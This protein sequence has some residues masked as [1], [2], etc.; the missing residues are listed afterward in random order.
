MNLMTDDNNEITRLL[1]H[2]EHPKET[3]YVRESDQ[4]SSKATDDFRK[5]TH[6]DCFDIYRCGVHHQKLLVNVPNPK[7]FLDLQGNPIAPLTQDFVN[8]LEAIAGSDYYTE[9]YDQAC[10]Y[11]PAIDLLNQRNPKVSG[12]NLGTILDVPH[13][14]LYNTIF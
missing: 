10:V 12:N 11:I 5:C 3:V 1:S 14:N 2:I 13:F 9:D 8:I 4:I 6:F 7:E